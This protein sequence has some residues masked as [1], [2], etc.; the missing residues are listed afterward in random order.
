RVT[1]G[2]HQVI[3]VEL[4]RVEL[5][6]RQRCRIEEPVD[7]TRYVEVRIEAAELSRAV[8]WPSAWEESLPAGCVGLLERMPPVDAHAVLPETGRKTDARRIAQRGIHVVVDGNVMRSRSSQRRAADTGPA[9][10]GA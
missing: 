4:R 1:R 10:R 5:A 3:R 7:H 8:R 2:N 6:P 9:R